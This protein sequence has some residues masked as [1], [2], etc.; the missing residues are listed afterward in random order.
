MESDKDEVS[1]SHCDSHSSNPECHEKKFPALYRYLPRF[2]T[3][4]VTHRRITADPLPVSLHQ[5]KY[6]GKW[7]LIVGHPGCKNTPGNAYARFSVLQILN[8]FKEF[9]ENDCQVFVVSTD[10]FESQREIQDS[11]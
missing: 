11:V 2:W 3:C 1:T 5:P 4:G 10:T 8:K 7:I 9:E 6:D